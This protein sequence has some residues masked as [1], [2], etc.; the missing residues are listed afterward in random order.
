MSPDK[1]LKLITWDTQ[2]GLEKCPVASTTTLN[3]DITIV[4]IS[5]A[6]CSDLIA[7]QASYDRGSN[8]ETTGTEAEEGEVVG[9]ADADA[10]ID[11]YLSHFSNIIHH[12]VIKNDKIQEF[13]YPINILNIET[14]E[15]ILMDVFNQLPKQK[16]A[17]IALEVGYV[18][19]HSVT[20]ELRYFFG[21]WNTTLGGTRVTLNSSNLESLKK[22]VEYYGSLDLNSYL[23]NNGLPSP[24]QLQRVVNIRCIVQFFRPEAKKKQIS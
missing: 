22:A 12:Y 11:D 8:F 4:P 15:K 16:M 18:L 7:E 17:V 5:E 13:N 21:S 19:R 3:T 2:T 6:A 23:N 9:G 20:E 10:E 1:K 14:I 24:W